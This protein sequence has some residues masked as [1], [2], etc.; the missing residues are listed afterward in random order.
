MP[1]N[2]AY[3]QKD[4]GLLHQAMWVAKIFPEAKLKICFNK[5]D[6][7]DIHFFKQNQQAQ[8]F[9]MVD[10]ITTFHA[11]DLFYNIE[12]KVELTLPGEQ[13]TVGFVSI[14]GANRKQNFRAR[15][16]DVDKNR[17]KSIP[18]IIWQ[19]GGGKLSEG[20]RGKKQRA[21]EKSIHHKWQKK[22]DNGSIKV[23]RINRSIGKRIRELLNTRKEDIRQRVRNN[24]FGPSENTPLELPDDQN[25]DFNLSVLRTA[26][27]LGLDTSSQETNKARS[28]LSS[29]SG[30]PS[31]RRVVDRYLETNPK[32]L[33]SIPAPE[34]QVDEF[35]RE[36]KS[37]ETKGHL[38][39]ASIPNGISYPLEA[40]KELTEIY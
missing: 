5:F 16:K 37:L 15:D 12:L 19:S 25:V 11:I 13:L 3:I 24:I 38:R 35:M 36:L 17:W 6:I 28:F 4:F 14:N 34:I 8:Q 40:L 10:K 31:A 29:E 39:P 26:V 27:Y 20:W 21:P 30:L 2:F 32:S 23:V 22:V 9:E 18:E 1:R 33:K 7:T